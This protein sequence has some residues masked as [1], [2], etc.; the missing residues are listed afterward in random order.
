[1]L[2]MIV[3]EM[4]FTAMLPPETRTAFNVTYFTGALLVATLLTWWFPYAVR[5]ERLPDGSS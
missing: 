4:I 1:M 2:A 5:L 3:L